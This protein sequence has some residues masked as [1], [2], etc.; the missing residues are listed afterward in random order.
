MP[1][2]VK[3]GEPRKMRG[4][5]LGTNT[6]PR[7]GRKRL[8]WWGGIETGVR[9]PREG[10][11]RSKGDPKRQVVGGCA[12]PIGPIRA[13]GLPHVASTWPRPERVTAPENNWRCVPKIGPI[14]GR[15]QS[16]KGGQ[17]KR[18]SLRTKSL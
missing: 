17:G 8:P 16:R 6:M 7:T 1:R 11:E 5:T 3:D 15:L 4:G 12:P 13:I 14:L 2:A 18:G 10:G 9:W